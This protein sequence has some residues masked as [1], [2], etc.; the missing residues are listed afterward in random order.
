MNILK[1]GIHNKIATAALLCASMT[2][3]PLY[4][5]TTANWWERWQDNQAFNEALEELGTSYQHLSEDPQKTLTRSADPTD[6]LYWQKRTM[7]IYGDAENDVYYLPAIEA[8]DPGRARTGTKGR[9]GFFYTYFYGEQGDTFT[10]TT[11]SQPDDVACYAGLENQYSDTI[12]T[13][14]QVKLNANHSTQYTMSEKGLML[15]GCRDKSSNYS[16][17]DTLV[18]VEVT[19]TTAKKHP[20]FIFGLNTKQEWKTFSQQS[21]PSGQTLLFD[22]RSRYVA[23]YSKAKASLNTN[24][25]QMLREQLTYV[26]DYDRVNG[27]DGSSYLHQ[28]LRGLNFGI[29]N[30]CCWSQGG[31]G[32]IGIG[33]GNNLPTSTS[34]GYWHE[35]GHQNQMT[36]TWDRLSE[37]TNNILSVSACRLLRGEVT[38]KSCHE[39][40]VYNNFSW[41]QQAVGSFL[42]SGETH[43]FDTDDNV[44]RK[45]MM[46][47]QL[48]T[49]WPDLYAYIGKAYREAYNEG[50]GKSQFATNQQKIDFFVV[51]A[52]KAAGHDLREFFTRWGLGYST[53]ADS[54]IAALKL[55][56]PKKVAK[57][58]T[59]S[60]NGTSSTVIKV[61]AEAKTVN[62]AFVTNTPSAGP[63]SLVW[64]GTGET[65][66]YAQVVDSRHRSFTV[67]LRAKTGHGACIANTVNSAINC[68]SGTS[69]FLD[70][71]YRAEDNPHL[72]QGSYTGVLRLI[73]TDWHNTDW[74]AN[75]NIDLSIVK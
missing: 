44:F 32:R 5:E 68:S 28:P 75:V 72:P 37:T 63:T 6:V 56:Q 45:L 65:P 10:F 59:G 15:L 64:K 43:Q 4:A 53:N 18:R 33:F 17:M 24:I 34:W 39:N 35:Y 11:S 31:D 8:H 55:P 61:P 52:S 20:L 23:N 3:F 48:K 69:A 46:F 67:K 73:A 36:W 66:L 13:K 47:T 41:D 54:Q 16:H 51:N 40:L 62:I 25:L 7:Q 58:F 49:S 60:L 70:V 27:L 19:S 50:K 74:S 1:S 14:Y 57:T 42:N 30:S 29:F 9:N 71:A 38:D 22:G 21:T 12:S 26:M 2:S